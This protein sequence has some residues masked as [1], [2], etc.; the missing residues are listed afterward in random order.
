MD[1]CK[2]SRGCPVTARLDQP[3]DSSNERLVLK[4]VH[5]D[6]TTSGVEEDFGEEQDLF[7]VTT[8]CQMICIETPK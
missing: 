6:I 5:K 4:L 2:V 1:V 8:T 7:L 3:R